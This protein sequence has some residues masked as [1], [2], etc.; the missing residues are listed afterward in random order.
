MSGTVQDWIDG[1]ADYGLGD[2]ISAASILRDINAVIQDVN[3]RQTWSFLQ[4]TAQVTLTASTAAVTLPTGFNKAISFVIDSLPQ[5]IQPERR[6]TIVKQYAGSLTVP[7]VPRNYYFIAGAMQLYPVPSTTYTGTLDY[8][9]DEVVVTA[10][11]TLTSLLMPL[12]HQ[13]VYEL[14]LIAKLFAV[15]DDTEMYGL[16]TNRFEKKIVDM[17]DDVTMHQLDMPDRMI[18]VWAD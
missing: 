2:D 12:K 13:D 17:M 1:L 5:V 16:F 3:S 15:E 4:A 6:E 8:Y 10:A 7:G 18:D 11:T 14:G 9:R